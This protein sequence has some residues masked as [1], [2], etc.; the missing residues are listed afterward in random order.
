MRNSALWRG[1]HW[2]RVFGIVFGD[3]KSQNGPPALQRFGPV[4]VIIVIVVLV[5]TLDGEG[6]QVSIPA[7]TFRFYIVA[8][9]ESVDVVYPAGGHRHRRHHQSGCW[10][11]VEPERTDNQHFTGQVDLLDPAFHFVIAFPAFNFLG[12]QTPLRGRPYLH[13]YT[14]L[15]LPALMSSKSVSLSICT[16]TPLMRKVRVLLS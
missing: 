13:K 16:S 14:V 12:Q 10:R 1:W 11:R 9:H 3:Y 5:F 8:D 7:A 2:H 6:F 4:I 15:R